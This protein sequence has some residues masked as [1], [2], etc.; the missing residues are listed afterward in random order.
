VSELINNNIENMIYEIRGKQ[1][2]LD[3]D[4]AKLYQCKNGT[5]EINQAVSRNMEKFPNRYS[6][7]LGNNELENLRSQNVTSSFNNNYGGRRYNTRVFTEQ[8]VAMLATIL[9]TSIAT[10]ISINIMDAFV[11]M[12]KYISNNLIEQNYI[13]NIVFEDHESIKLLQEFFTKLEKN[14]KINSIFFEGQIYDAYSLLIDI[15]TC[16]KNE[17]I[18][19]DNYAGKEL[20]DIIKNVKIAIKL[21][22]KN[23]NQELINKYKQE[24]S[25]VEFIINNKFH[26]RFIIIDNNILY[27]SGA[28]FKDIGKKCFALTKI[29]D[30]N[31]LNNILKC[32]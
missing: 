5:K 25:N 9:K 6:W 26:D 27:H 18:I 23:F 1:V 15:L 29:I 11:N 28:S 20:L 12:R 7:I 17:I 3:S 14:Q 4:L 19:I 2:M 16:A 32:L 31:I 8:G 24:Y 10:K 22:S 21:V 30:E 13:N